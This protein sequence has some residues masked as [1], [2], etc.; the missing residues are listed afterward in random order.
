MN[1][2]ERSEISE[3]KSGSSV[4][5]EPY[6][7]Y[8]QV[9]RAW[10]VAYGIGVPVLLLSQSEVV[11]KIIPSGN[12]TIII[13]LFLLGVSIQ[14]LVALIYK[15][16]MAILYEHENCLSI[17][18]S[19]RYK[20]A[21]YFSEKYWPDAIGDLVTICVYIIGTYVI[22]TTMLTGPIVSGA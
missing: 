19:L 6:R 18:N 17:A 22:A 21:R 3:E 15:Y 1:P 8:S 4:Y 9:L 2:S 20:T 7:H 13:F 16:S 12:G 5:F 14:V 11:V 10:L